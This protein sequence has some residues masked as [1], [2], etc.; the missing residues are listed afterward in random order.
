MKDLYN[1]KQTLERWIFKAKTEL[2]EPD[3]LNVLQLVEYMQENNKSISGLY[4]V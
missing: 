4:D 1:R 2:N 3:R